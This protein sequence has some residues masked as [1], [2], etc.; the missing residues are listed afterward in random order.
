VTHL[1][2]SFVVDFLRETS[3]GAEGPATAAWR[4]GARLVTRD[5]KDF[6]GVQGLETITY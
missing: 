1:D 5:R 2:T 3:R 6:L 4:D